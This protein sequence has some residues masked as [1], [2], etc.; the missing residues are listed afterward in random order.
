MFFASDGMAVAAS[1]AS[2]KGATW[3]I[4]FAAIAP[5]SA[6]WPRSALTS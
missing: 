3:L 2:S 5:N 1:I 6:A 4:P